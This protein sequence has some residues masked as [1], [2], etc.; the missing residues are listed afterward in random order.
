[1]G[2]SVAFAAGAAVYH[3]QKKIKLPVYHFYI[4]TA[5]F[6]THLIFSWWVW[7]FPQSNKGQNVLFA[8]DHFGLFGQIVT[9]SYV[10]WS[11]ADDT[12]LKSQFPSLDKFGRSLGNISYGVFLTHWIPAI[13]ICGFGVSFKDKLTL[14]PTTIILTNVIAIVLY[15]CVEQPVNSHFRDRIRPKTPVSPTPEQSPQT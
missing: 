5:L 4:A 15:R 3:L 6:F 7:G 12:H 8:S 13:I 10:M 9:A 14:V 2:S 1:M 11:L